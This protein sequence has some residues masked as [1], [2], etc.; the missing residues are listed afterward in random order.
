MR[1]FPRN[2]ILG[3]ALAG[4]AAPGLKAQTFHF[5][6]VALGTT[7]PFVA[8]AGGVSALFSNV[9]P[10]VADAFVV[11]DGDQIGVVTLVGHILVDDRPSDEDPSIPEGNVLLIEFDRPLSAVSFNFALNGGVTD[12]IMLQA[13]LGATP[14]G[15]ATAS[16][17]LPPGMSI[18]EGTLAFDA[19]ASTFDR[20]FV[21]T[22][23]I[24]FAMDAMAVRVAATT[25]PEPASV[26]LLGT[27]LAGLGAIGARRRRRAG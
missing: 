24:S 6:D 23:A 27:G 9:G 5:E 21:G 10:G 26:L 7:S 13:F 17:V 15:S 18:P 25:V 12:Q 14:M 16:G 11:L 20:V 8:T 2:L 22:H 1:A 3:A 19:G 4:L